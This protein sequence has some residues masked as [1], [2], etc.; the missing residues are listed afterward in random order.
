MRTTPTTTSP[1]PR[2][3]GKCIE[4]KLVSVPSHRTSDNGTVR[5][6]HLYDNGRYWKNAPEVFQQLRKKVMRRKWP[7]LEATKLRARDRKAT[8]GYRDAGS[9]QAADAAA[10]KLAAD[11]ARMAK[12]DA[13]A[14]KRAADVE[15]RRVRQEE[16]LARA[17]AAAEKRAQ[18][19]A[20]ERRIAVA[21]EADAK[22]VKAAAAIEKQRVKKA[23]AAE[24]LRMIRIEKELK[25]QAKMSK[26]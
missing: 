18:R 6:R 11:G 3:D 8:C 12:E 20:H 19:E 2:L 7:E 14:T 25:K 21:E 24:K 23:A 16:A 10:A 17:A 4:T 26:E 15:Q 22:R 13:A 9:K 1:P 5:W